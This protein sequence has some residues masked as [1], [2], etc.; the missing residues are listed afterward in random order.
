MR[1]PH[2]FTIDDMPEDERPRRT[3]FYKQPQPA[4]KP[5]PPRQSAKPAPS[6]QPE[7]GDPDQTTITIQPSDWTAFQQLIFDA[8]LP[9]ADAR[10]ALAE[11]FDRF[12]AMHGGPLYEPA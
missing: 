4:A 5:E 12:R 9:F 10:A 8:L 3:I 7:P 1:V 2:T 11:A 6:P